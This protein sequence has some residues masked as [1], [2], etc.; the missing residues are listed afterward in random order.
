LSSSFS[1]KR[2]IVCF[3]ISVGLTF[4]VLTIIDTSE[5]VVHT[6]CTAT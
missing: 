5:M 3:R 2:P 6:N 1:F 4:L